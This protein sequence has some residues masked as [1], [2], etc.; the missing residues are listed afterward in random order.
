MKVKNRYL[1]IA[2]GIISAFGVIF[3]A[4]A[5]GT[6]NWVEATPKNPADS[7]DGN[8][9]AGLFAGEK[10]LPSG[11]GRER[12]TISVHSELKKS[13]GSSW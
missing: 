7:G 5:M 1:F 3:I 6:E 12:D 13:C 4:V 8:F 2:N 9:N 10:Y 11:A